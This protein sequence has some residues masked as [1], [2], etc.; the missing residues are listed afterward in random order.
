MTIDLR[1]SSLAE[2]DQCSQEILEEVRALADRSGL[3]LEVRE[4]VRTEPMDMNARIIQTMEK[5]CQDIGVPHRRMDSGA[6][7]DAIWMARTWPTGML[8]VPSA[9]GISH[10]PKEFTDPLHVTLGAQVL[11][12][13][14]LNIDR[15]EG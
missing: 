15:W 8:F 2:L 14:I 7:H 9:G 12:N 5:E 3:S 10:S 6:G 13:T 4:I 1:G 11:L